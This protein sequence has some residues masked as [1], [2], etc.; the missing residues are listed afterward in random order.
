MQ[1]SA[2]RPLII[3][4]P[5]ECRQ[6]RPCWK[7]DGT[8]RMTLALFS[9]CVRG[10]SIVTWAGLC[11]LLMGCVRQPVPPYQASDAAEVVSEF[12]RQQIEDALKRLFGSPQFPRMAFVSDEAGE[13]DDDGAA[14]DEQQPAVVLVDTVDPEW[15]KQGAVIYRR[16][17]A[18]CHGVTGDG[19]GPAAAYLQPKPRDYRRGIFKFTSTPYGAKPARHDLV[20]VL[21]RGAKGTSMP[22]FPWLPDDELEAVIDYVIL[23]SQRGEL[24]QYALQL[25]RYDYDED[26]EIDFMEFVD[27]L[28]NI[29]E[30]WQEADDLVVSPLTPEPSYT[31]ESILAGR[32]VF[33][34]EKNGCYKCHGRDAEGQTHWLSHEFLSTQE[35][36]PEDQRQ[37]INYDDWGYPAPAADLTARFLH[38]GRRPIDIYRRI[39]TGIN[40]TPMPAFSQT[41][42]DDPDKIW[43]LVHYVM[44]IVEGKGV[45]PEEKTGQT[46][47]SGRARRENLMAVRDAS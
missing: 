27:G 35:S 41:F 9:R 23:L 22:A 6:A 3:R 31:Q 7:G 16:R 46:A 2:A 40:G 5:A 37:Q 43:H 12:H 44:S 32:R 30:A 24:E 1:R 25:A 34:D 36:L 14:G 39:Y 21:R 38:G 29:R 10:D 4:V 13:Q 15:L 20:R 28:A 26:E 33:L 19:N 11:L 17:C 18:G 45:R 8:A 47:R 42:S